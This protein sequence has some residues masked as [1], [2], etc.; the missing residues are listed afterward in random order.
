MPRDTF[1]LG[2]RVK[3]GLEEACA[4]GL[5]GAVPSGTWGREAA[6]GDGGKGLG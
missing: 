3:S 6:P 1:F 2:G 5:G 4:L